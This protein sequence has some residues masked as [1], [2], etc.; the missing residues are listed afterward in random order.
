MGAIGLGCRGYC[1]VDGPQRP[2]GAADELGGTGGERAPYAAAVQIWPLFCATGPASG[3]W[4]NPG[5]AGT[6]PGPRAG[7]RHQA[8]LGPASLTCPPPGQGSAVTGLAHRP[9]SPARTSRPVLAAVGT[10]AQ[11][12]GRTG[13]ADGPARGHKVAGTA[14]PAHRASGQRAVETAVA[15]FAFT[16][17]GTPCDRAYSSAA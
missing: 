15:Q 11:R 8:V 6:K 2:V 12:F 7:G 17:M 3:Q 5:A 4:G 16:V 1:F 10:A 13:H 14:P 9:F